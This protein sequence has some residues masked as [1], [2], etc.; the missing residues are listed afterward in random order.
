MIDAANM[1]TALKKNLITKNALIEL[2]NK[3]D[4]IAEKYPQVSFISFADSLLIK[5]NWTVGRFNT[6]VSYQYEPEIFFSV[7]KEIK[8]AFFETIDLS[9]YGIFCQGENAYY[10][11]PLLHISTSNNH[12]CLNSLGTP[13]A[14]L[15]AIESAA[16]SSIRNKIHAP[17]E[18]YLDEH[19]LH[20]IKTK[21]HYDKN[22][23][24][25]YP[26]KFSDGTND[27]YYAAIGLEEITDAITD[28]K[29]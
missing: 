12:I 3:I 7:F 9:I 21:Y 18:L 23:L 8:L 2:R 14:Q 17:S 22:K 15:A 29:S 5:S 13:F 16:R 25:S 4:I 20:S 19:F 28:I 27:N 26:Y 24:P 1:K 6:G 11:E 10:D